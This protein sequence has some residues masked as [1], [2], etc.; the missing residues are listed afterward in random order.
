M[1]QVVHQLEPDGLGDVLGVGGSQ[2]VPSAD[3]P[4]QR[5]VPLNECVPRLILAIAGAH[6]QSGDCQVIAHWVTVPS[7]RCTE[8]ARVSAA[9]VLRYSD[10]GRWALTAR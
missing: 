3:R 8:A 6:H 4:D 7:C 9:L 5:G 1:A 10:N 2:P